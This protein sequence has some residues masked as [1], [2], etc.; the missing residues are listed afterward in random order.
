MLCIAS[1]LRR[2]S[3]AAILVVYLLLVYI[4]PHLH[5]QIARPPTSLDNVASI[6]RALAPAS[7]PSPQPIPARPSAQRPTT[8]PPSLQSAGRPD[9]LTTPLRV[10]E[11]RPAVHKARDAVPTTAAALGTAAV[12]GG[13]LAAASRNTND[14]SNP[15]ENTTP[16]G[17]HDIDGDGDNDLPEIRGNNADPHLLDRCRRLDEHPDPCSIVATECPSEGIVNY[18]SLYYCTLNHIRPI[19][20]VVAV[21]LLLVYFYLLY[22]ISDLYLASALQQVSNYLNMSNEV[23]GLTLLSF[24]NSAPDFFTALAGVST[25]GVELILSSSISGGIF[26]LTIVF[27][28]I[29]LGSATYYNRSATGRGDSENQ[30][31]H[32]VNSPYHRTRDTALGGILNKKG[33]RRIRRRLRLLTRPLRQGTAIERRQMAEAEREPSDLGSPAALTGAGLPGASTKRNSRHLSDLRLADSPEMMAAAQLSVPPAPPSSPRPFRG[34]RIPVFHWLRSAVVY[35]SA[36]AALTIIVFRGSMYYYE[37]ILLFSGYILFLLSYLVHYLVRAVRRWK[38]QRADGIAHPDVPMVNEKGTIVKP[39]GPF[40]DPPPIRIPLGPRQAQYC[41]AHLENDVMAAVTRPTSNGRLASDYFLAVTDLL[42]SFDRCRTRMVGA[43]LDMVRFPIHLAVRFTVP[44]TFNTVAE[45]E[46]DDDERSLSSSSDGDLTDDDESNRDI[47]NPLPPSARPSGE[48]TSREGLRPYLMDEDADD[49]PVDPPATIPHE[50]PA[51][52]STERVATWYHYHFYQKRFSSSPNLPSDEGA[53][54]RKRSWFGELAQADQ[55]PEA[56]SPSPPTQPAARPH[57][58]DEHTR[59]PNSEVTLP[60]ARVVPRIFIDDYTQDQPTRREWLSGSS[61]NTGTTCSSSS[62]YMYDESDSDTGSIE[63]VTPPAAPPMTAN[64]T[65]NPAR[66]AS[67][68]DFD[69]ADLPSPRST[70]TGYHTAHD[71]MD[72]NGQPAIIH[73]IRPAPSAGLR[74]SIYSQSTGRGTDYSTESYYS[75]PAN[76]RGHRG[77]S[78]GFSDTG[79]VIDPE[80]NPTI[81]LPGIDPSLHHF[82]EVAAGTDH[83][84]AGPEVT[85]VSASGSVGRPRGYS[86]PLALASPLSDGPLSPPILPFVP[87]VTT[88]PAYDSEPP[89]ATLP[90]ITPVP[91]DPPHTSSVRSSM[92]IQLRR[93]R[94]PARSKAWRPTRSMLGFMNRLVHLT[95]SDL[96]KYRILIAAT[97]LLAPPFILFIFGQN[98]D[99]L[100]AGIQFGLYDLAAVLGAL[101]ALGVWLLTWGL[102]RLNRVYGHVYANFDHRRRGRG[103]FHLPCM[104]LFNTQGTTPATATESQAEGANAGRGLTYGAVDADEDTVAREKAAACRGPAPPPA[105]ALPTGTS[106]WLSPK[107]SSAAV[108]EGVSWGHRPVSRRSM[109]SAVSIESTALPEPPS[110]PFEKATARFLTYLHGEQVA[111]TNALR[112]AQPEPYI[113]AEN[114]YFI[115]T[116]YGRLLPSK[117]IRR[118]MYT[119]YF[120]ELV[121]SV[122]AFVVCLIWIY[123]TANELV[124]LLET[125]GMLLDLPDRVLGSTVLAWGNSM[126]DL[127]ADLAMARAGYFYVAITAVFTSPILNVMLSLGIN[128]FIGIVRSEESYMPMPKLSPSLLFSLFFL[129]FVVFVICIGY[130]AVILKFR[131]P[132]YFGFVLIALFVLYTIGTIIAELLTPY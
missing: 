55:S 5:G 74:D 6:P 9:H 40:A 50:I 125:V 113:L 111:L 69:A 115:L 76:L 129:L 110:M 98:N 95:P 63:E 130:V 24:G 47:R 90:A 4:V 128:F 43:V 28:A 105:A 51:D 78:P 81:A 96:R 57:L 3:L 17:R 53:G 124:A 71:S 7:A 25:D 41:R 60:A 123:A 97:A 23:A 94:S 2:G 38:T 102:V 86:D 49:S 45:L 22:H 72:S 77:S 20:Y 108:R 85:T 65:P 122:L 10:P 75:L 34:Y 80:F 61:F 70:V 131:L 127:F 66:P 18:L 14:T 99:S 84:A 101:Y 32:A 44:P 112:E 35:G 59:T 67:L 1:L 64:E 36:I 91:S 92:A 26:V 31:D 54:G 114:A 30:A 107:P 73:D 15:E 19:F 117:R 132:R 121:L 13:A 68:I 33:F 27:G 119:Q 29:I 87:C 79:S 104:D 120:V 126:G 103:Q 11:R 52:P 48:R 109:L 93:Q 116:R 106:T 100:A 21:L 88:K 62:G 39:T 42:P 8:T 37:A 56:S 58:E 12:T 46:E 83:W 89:S 16:T 118:Q 82:E